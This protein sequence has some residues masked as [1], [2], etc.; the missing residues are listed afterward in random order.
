MGRAFKL[1]GLVVGALVL[2]GVIV[3][4]AVGL[5]VDPNDYKDEIQAA[6]ADATGRDVT[7][8]GDLELGFF[9]G[10]RIAL[11]PAELANAQGFGDEPFARIERAELDLAILPLLT[12]RIEIGAARLDGL[13]LNLARDASGADNWSDLGG[14]GE[15]ATPAAETPAAEAPAAETGGAPLNLDVGVLEIANANVTYE[16]AATGSSWRLRDF[17]LDASDFGADTR[18]PLSMQFSLS[19]ADMTVDVAADTEATLALAENT[20]RLDELRVLIGGSGPGW[21][22]G[23]D[24]AE[25]TFDTFAANLDAG[26]LDLQNL[27]L[28]FL[29]MTVTGN[30]S[31]RDLLTNLALSGGIEIAE[32]NPQDLLE[33]F[34]AGIETADPDVLRRASASANFVY[35]ANETGLRDMSLMLDD[36]E[37]E[38]A[39]GM[40]GE[41]LTF[42][43]D[44]DEINIDRYLPPPAEDDPEA[45]PD[46]GSIDEVDLPLDLLSTLSADG[47]FD[48]GQAQFTGLQL[49]DARFTLTA[50]DG[51]IRLVPT[52]SLY[53]GTSEGEIG[54]DVEGDTARFSIVETVSDVDMNPLASDYLDIDALSGTGNVSLNLTSQGANIGQMRRDLDGDVAFSVTDGAW[55]GIDVWYELRRA[56]AVTR[57]DSAPERPDGPR[58]TEFSNLSA[59]GVVEDA[60]LTNEDFNA[61]LPFMTVNGTG[62]VNLLDNALDF[63]LTA[64]FAD[65][66][67]VQSDPLMSGLAGDALP[68]TV[69]GTLDAPAIRPDFG[70]VVRERAR[71]EVQQEV[72]EEREEVEERV[73]DR[74][75]DLVQ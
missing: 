73:R 25:L 55:A 51:E 38:G 62:T 23:A 26:T 49:T 63:E 33:K 31:G 37:L 54:I 41:T 10:I 17:R 34:D 24:E 70:A 19:G 67:L 42:S 11:G 8:E 16:D 4:I 61:T 13:T 46:E 12:R 5:F 56:R 36:S 65:N 29:D 3:V 6:A 48:L 50:E 27:M 74:L 44:L 57:G 64:A 58:R 1:V 18:F 45:E 71:E 21:P 40:Q 66:E 28:D 14:A 39:L 72:D 15:T 60:L 30:L 59:S 43:L 68:L 32:F 2:L 20:Y 9:P 69:G 7:L 53:G 22:A 75:R 35:N 52:A 47:D